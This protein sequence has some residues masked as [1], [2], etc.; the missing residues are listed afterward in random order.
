MDCDH[1]NQNMK[2]EGDEIVH[3]C[4]LCH[5]VWTTPRRGYDTASDTAE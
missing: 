1:K 5:E 4:R 2:W 3:T